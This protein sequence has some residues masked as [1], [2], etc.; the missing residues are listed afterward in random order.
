MKSQGAVETRVVGQLLVGVDVE[1]VAAADRRGK[2]ILTGTWK[3]KGNP[4]LGLWGGFGLTLSGPSARRL[5]I[6]RLRLQGPLT[7]LK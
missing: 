1:S 4:K 2:Q 6:L 5:G 3:G 7:T